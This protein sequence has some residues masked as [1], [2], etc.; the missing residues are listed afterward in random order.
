MTMTS[1]TLGVDHKTKNN[2]S[3]FHEIISLFNDF[4]LHEDT[5]NIAL[6]LILN[7][8]QIQECRI[9]ITKV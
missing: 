5:L 2:H 4:N 9:I 1:S 3:L 8:C 7:C 6:L